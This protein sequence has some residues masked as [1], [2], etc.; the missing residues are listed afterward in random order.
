MAKWHYAGLR[1]DRLAL[2]YCTNCLKMYV[3]VSPTRCAPLEV[4]CPNCKA[5]M[6]GAENEPHPRNCYTCRDL[7]NCEL[8]QRF[9]EDMLRED[10][11]CDCWRGR[12][13]GYGQA[14]EV[15]DNFEDG[16]WT[17]DDVMKA[18]DKI[19]SMETINAVKKDLLLKAV[20][21]L[22]QRVEWDDYWNR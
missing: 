6:D 8:N 18:I 13:M 2:Y 17:E 12:M 11:V 4:V 10:G 20:R 16:E 9:T 3:Q 5:E 22:R 21:F 7:E 15:L 1:D 19:L 14:I